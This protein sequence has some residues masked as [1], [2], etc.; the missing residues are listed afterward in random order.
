[1]DIK[2]DTSDLPGLYQSADSASLKEQKKYFRAIGIYSI[3]LVFAALFAFWSDGNE[4]PTA[5]IIST[6][7]F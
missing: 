2:V 1:M 5:K 7:F 3:L 6:L 4:N